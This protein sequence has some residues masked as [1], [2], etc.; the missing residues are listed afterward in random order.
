MKTVKAFAPATVANVVCGY[1]ILGFAIEQPGDTVELS[2]ND[3]GKVTLDEITG[4]GGLLPTDP[5]RNLASAV[6]IQYLQTIGSS[7]QGVSVK[8]Y[9]GMPLNSGMGS[10]SASSVASL[11]AI[12][13]LMGEPMSRAELL[14]LAM[15]GE[16]LACGSAHADNVAPALM[17]GLVLVRSNNPVDAVKLPVP[18]TLYCTV[19]HPDVDVPTSESRRILKERVPVR[20]AI[21]QWGNVG[22]M[23]AGFCLGDTSLIARSMEDVIF[24]PIRAMLIP[25]FYQMKQAAIQEGALGFGISGSGPSVF[26]LSTNID[27]ANSISETLTNML[28]KYDI[29]SQS[30][31][32]KINTTGARIL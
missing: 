30:F 3:S 27:V 10:S 6:V 8:L 17:G 25:R 21:I 14:P 18:D 7:H 4:E 28:R 13:H 24:E 19:V 23:V 20:D 2:L 26:A 15:E 31:V 5:E 1:D 11:V 32:S 22:G 29:E 9:K 12:N 16:R